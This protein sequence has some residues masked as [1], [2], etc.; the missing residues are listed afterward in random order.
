VSTFHHGLAVRGR[1]YCRTENV[2]ACSGQ[3]IQAGEKL[4]FGMPQLDGGHS[5]CARFPPDWT[6]PYAVR[7]AKEVCEM[8]DDCHGFIMGHHELSTFHVCFRAATTAVG[9]PTGVCYERHSNVSTCDPAV[10]DS[11]AL[12]DFEPDSAALDVAPLTE[13][14]VLHA[15]GR[16]VR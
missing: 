3:N 12:C 6:V 9:A 11:N 1:G 16:V 7:R 13:A 10:C 14:R 15:G 5:H 8:H 4:V 2:K